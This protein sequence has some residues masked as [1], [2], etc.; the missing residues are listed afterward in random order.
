DGAGQH[1]PGGEVERPLQEQLANLLVRLLPDPGVDRLAC[2]FRGGEIDLL[3]TGAVALLQ[4]AEET[5]LEA[6]A[7]LPPEV[8]GQR[9]LHAALARLLVEQLAGFAVGPVR[10][11]RA[12]G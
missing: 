4:E 5:F 7:A 8:C 2:R 10:V 12:G 1:E 6:I 11:A 3:Q 9:E